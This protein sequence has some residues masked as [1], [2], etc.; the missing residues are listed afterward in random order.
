MLRVTRNA[1]GRVGVLCYVRRRTGNVMFYL[2]VQAT[3]CLSSTG[4]ANG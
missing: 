4:S 2:N 3:C 1:F